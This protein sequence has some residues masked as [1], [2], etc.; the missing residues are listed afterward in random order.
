MPRMIVMTTDLQKAI[1][2]KHNELRNKIASGNEMRFPTATRM[3]AFSW[4]NML[5]KLAELNCKQCIMQHDKC[6]NTRNYIHR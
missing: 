2:D 1:M 3:S 5:A 6:R 4:D